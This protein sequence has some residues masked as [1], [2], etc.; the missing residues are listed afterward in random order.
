[1]SGIIHLFFDNN[2][3]KGQSTVESA[4]V[5]PLLPILLMG[6]IDYGYLFYQFQAMHNASR[7]RPYCRGIAQA[8]L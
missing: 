7:L 6:I 1:M 5:L 2:N 3:R 4:L 8:V